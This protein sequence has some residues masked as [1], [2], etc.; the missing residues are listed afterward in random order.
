M[1]RMRTKTSCESQGSGQCSLGGEAAVG[2]YMFEALASGDS[3]FISE[4]LFGEKG[5]ANKRG[6]FC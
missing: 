3:S 2:V 1:T 4:V 5:P 6:S